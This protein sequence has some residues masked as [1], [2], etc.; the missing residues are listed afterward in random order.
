MKPVKRLE[1]I[2]DRSERD[3]ILAAL[4]ASGAD[5]WT[6][7][8][9]TSGHG[10]RSERGSIGLPGSPENDFILAAVDAARLPA[11]LEKLRPILGRWGGVCLVSDAQWLKHGPE[12]SVP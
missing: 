11:L 6:I 2:V 3:R 1:I 7:L 10:D 5:G 8:P 9:V 4:S 12:E